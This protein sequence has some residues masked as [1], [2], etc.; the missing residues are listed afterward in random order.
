MQSLWAKLE[1]EKDYSTNSE[2]INNFIK[3]SNPE[4]P[5]SSCI[6]HLCWKQEERDSLALL[7]KVC[8]PAPVNS[9][10][11]LLSFVAMANCFLARSHGF[12]T[13]YL[14]NSQLWQDLQC[15]EAFYFFIFLSFLFIGL[16][17]SQP[18]CF[19]LFFRCTIMGK[20]RQA[21]LLCTVPL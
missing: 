15:W 1:W 14:E 20:K 8:L 12:S 19:S 9:L 10:I 2:K 11:N 6:L 16:W 21:P 3:A 5:I 17:T 13:G 18:N 4:C 7:T